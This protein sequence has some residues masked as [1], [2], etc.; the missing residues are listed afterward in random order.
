MRFSLK[1]IMPELDVRLWGLHLTLIVP[2][3]FQKI[4]PFFLK[5]GHSFHPKNIAFFCV[6]KKNAQVWLIYVYIWFRIQD[7]RPRRLLSKETLVQGDYS[8]R[9]KF[10]TSR[11]VPFIILSFYNQSLS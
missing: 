9:C 5:R 3:H 11:A 6:F 10:E 2:G 7:I 8:P 1:T 4:Y